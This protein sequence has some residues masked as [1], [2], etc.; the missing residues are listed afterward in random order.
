MSGILPFNVYSVDND[1]DDDDDDD[2]HNEGEENEDKQSDEEEIKKYISGKRK[3]LRFLY[4][5]FKANIADG[6]Y[7]YIQTLSTK[8]LSLHTQLTYMKFEIYLSYVRMMLESMLKNNYKILINFKTLNNKNRYIT[9]YTKTLNKDLYENLI[10]KELTDFVIFNEVES[11]LMNILTCYLN[12]LSKDRS[13]E[14]IRKFKTEKAM[15][16]ITDNSNLY[17]D[18]IIQ[19]DQDDHL[20]DDKRVI[21]FIDKY[22]N[23]H[24]S[25]PRI[26]IFLKLYTKIANEEN[27]KLDAKYFDSLGD[28]YNKNIKNNNDVYKNKFEKLFDIADLVITAQHYITLIKNYKLEIQNEIM[29]I[30]DKTENT[31]FGNHIDVLINNFL[32]KYIYDKYS[33]AN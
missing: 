29:K 26:F 6:F 2:K 15:N 14:D 16:C 18:L 25:M 31:M 13:F 17:N 1:N 12:S 23:N 20:D 9:G 4:H 3:L 21:Q 10:T 11:N 19:E 5:L 30:L 33:E 7:N 8:Q 24:E 27:Y 28:E 32:Q 22:L